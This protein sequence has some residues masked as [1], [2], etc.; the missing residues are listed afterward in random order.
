MASSKEAQAQNAEPKKESSEPVKK[1]EGE[2]LMDAL[3]KQVEYYFS[4]EN[5]CQDAYLVSKMDAQH[6]VEI[7]VISDFKMVKQLTSD[8]T[9]ILESVKDSD[10][11]V[12]DLQN[13]KIKPV[14]VNA[15]TTL[16]LRNIPSTATEESVRALLSGDGCPKVLALRSDVGDNWFASFETEET[17]KR[18]LE[19]AKKLTWEGKPIGCA[20]KSENL[21]RGLSPG[22]PP[23]GVAAGSQGGYYV[24]MPYMQ[25]NGSYGAQYSYV[26]QDGQGYRHGGRGQGRRGPGGPGAVMGNGVPSGAD[27]M[28]GQSRPRSSK[29]GKARNGGRDG[30]GMGTQAP[31]KE[32]PQAP[33]NLADFP[34][35]EGAGKETTGYM[36]PFKA[37]G[38]DQIMSIIGS[39]E[40]PAAEVCL[41]FQFSGLS[42]FSGWRI[43]GEVF[44]V[45][46]SLKVVMLPGC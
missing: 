32:Q 17:T 30:N 1:L 2:E 22:S 28:D 37:Y 4:R 10:K 12:V 46:Y 42:A 11:V 23:K 18:A 9:L 14:A 29:K 35:L 34:K 43:I 36:K 21:L 15:R 31:Q 40:Y 3:K 6:Y 13:K 25:A 7:A 20:I 5:L 8:Q 33:I 39:T 45:K 19:F 26:T 38:K 44:M 16:I 24:P 27:G 41:V